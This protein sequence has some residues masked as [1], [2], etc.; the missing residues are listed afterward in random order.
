MGNLFGDA[1]DA[2]ENQGGQGGRRPEKGDLENAAEKAVE[3]RLG[4]GQGQGQG[5][6]GQ[7]AGGQGGQDMSG[8]DASGQGRLPERSGAD[9]SDRGLAPLPA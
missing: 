1:K 4:G 8:Q 5:Q 6:S 3:Q 9:L 7:D 2:L